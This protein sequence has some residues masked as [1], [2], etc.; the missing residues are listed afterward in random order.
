MIFYTQVTVYL[1]DLLLRELHLQ[2]SSNSILFIAY[3][4]TIY[5][6]K[7]AWVFFYWFVQIEVWDY[8][9]SFFS[10][11]FHNNL[12]FY[13]VIVIFLPF[14]LLVKRTVA[15]NTDHKEH[16]IVLARFYLEKT[17]TVNS[18]FF[19]LKWNCCLLLR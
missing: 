10:L 6:L 12:M 19:F 5:L 2:R 1:A 15:I 8:F 13:T 7:V 4:T 18:R 3:D 16:F 9:H 11:D 17:P 14:I